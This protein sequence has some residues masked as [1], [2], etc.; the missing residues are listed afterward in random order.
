M[1][2]KFSHINIL[3]PSFNPD[4]NL[5]TLVNDLSRYNWNKIIIINDGSSQA[6]KNIYR[7]LDQIDNVNIVSHIANKGKGAALKTGI[8]HINN[9]ISN[10]QGIITVDADGQHLIEDIIKIAHNATQHC[11]DVIFGVRNFGHNTPFRSK[12]GNNIT[13]YLLHIFHGLSI[14]D[15][16]TGLRYLPHAL[17]DSLLE[18]PGN[19]YE[20][21]FECLFIIN[22]LGYKITQVP[23]QTV[24]FNHNQES[25]FKPLIDSVKIYIVFIKFSI[26]GL[27]SFAVDILIFALILPI[28]GAVFPATIIARAISSIPNFILNRTLVFQTHH[29]NNLKN[30]SFYYISLWTFLA[31]LSGSFVSIAENSPSHIIIPLKIFVDFLLFFI[32][33]YIQKNIVFRK[34]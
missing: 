17:L 18:L 16:Q 32:S 1:N 14:D 33:F 29:N 26:S 8:H 4:T 23:I 19:R 11:D 12:F 30:E 21:E 27:L 6:H 25:H 24:Y 15:T 7:N 9:N 13:K 2:N 22:D 28:I 31:I 20:Y 34:I 10:S 3:I 5:I